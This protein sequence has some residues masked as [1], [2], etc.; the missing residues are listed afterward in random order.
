MVKIPLSLPFASTSK[1][2]FT[3][4]TSLLRYLKLV[5]SYDTNLLG[6]FSEVAAP[7]PQ[8]PFLKRL[9][10]SMRGY[11]PSNSVS[12]KAASVGMANFVHDARREG[13]SSGKRG[14]PVV[15]TG[16]NLKVN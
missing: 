15:R 8:W 5:F 16:G 2:K 10:E 12:F 4:L 1:D 3:K 11:F 6:D 13:T 9:K 14:K 7:E